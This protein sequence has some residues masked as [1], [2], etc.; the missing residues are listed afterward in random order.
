MGCGGVSDADELHAG[1]Q[2]ADDEKLREIGIQDQIRAA[3]S[4]QHADIAAPFTLP[5]VQVQVQPSFDVRIALAAG[6]MVWLGSRA[7]PRP[8]WCDCVQLTCD[9][10]Y[11]HCT[12]LKPCDVFG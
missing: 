8:H 10:C 6:T 3:D 1:Q 7:M 4:L 9:F 2:P 12:H 5:Q 11:M